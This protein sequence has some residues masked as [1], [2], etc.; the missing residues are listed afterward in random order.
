MTSGTFSWEVKRKMNNPRVFATPLVYGG[1]IFVI[2]GCDQ[3][4]APLDTFEYYETAKRKWHNLPSMETKRAAPA[5]QVVGDKIVAIGGVGETQAPVDAVEVYDIKAK[6]WFKMESLTEPLQ[7]VSSILRD[8]QILV[9][10]GMSDDSNPKDHFWSYDVENNKWKALPSM[11]TPRYASAAFEIDNKLYVI[12]GRQGKL[13]CLAFEVF[14]FATNKWTQL[15]DIPSKRVFPNYVRAGTCIVS[16]GGLKQPASEG[17]S[18]ACEVFDTA[19]QNPQWKIGVN[20]PTKRGDFAI[21][22][23]GNK[24]ICAG[25]LGSQ[26]KPLQ[27]V[28]AYDWVGDTWSEIKACPTTHCSCAFTMHDDRL[29]VIG[30]LSMAGPS[31]SMEALSFK[32]DK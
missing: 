11:P 12:G 24:V 17:F 2:G 25:G 27:M 32:P 10:G 9:M 21:G 7:G 29:L 18:Q 5:A 28:E 30:G 15:P 6:K 13:P 3:T 22:V 8:N 26:G 19:A 14:D 20:M 4:G 31:S 16:V 23:V 1:N